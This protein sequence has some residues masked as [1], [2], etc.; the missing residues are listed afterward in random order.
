MRRSS[1]VLATLVTAACAAPVADIG[2]Y[3]V[4][5]TEV[6]PS[7]GAATP[8][9]TVAATQSPLT[10]DDWAEAEGA[11]RAYCASQDLAFVLLPVSRSHTQIRFDEGVWS[12][13]AEC[14]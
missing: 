10:R 14:V 8:L 13:V 2:P 1:L 3:S 7:S 4:T 9:I 5:R 6:T 11:A 12:F